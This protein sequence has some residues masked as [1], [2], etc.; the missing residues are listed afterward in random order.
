MEMKFINQ[1][2]LHQELS[3]QGLG[4]FPFIEWSTSEIIRENSFNNLNINTTEIFWLFSYI[5]SNIRSTFIQFYDYN[6]EN[7]ILGFP[8]VQ[9]ELRHSIETF[10][11]LN[12]LVADKNYKCVL[13]YCSNS[14]KSNRKDIKLGDYKRF[15]HTNK[16]F[17]IQSKYEISK[18]NNKK[19]LKMA[20]ASNSY[21]HPDVYLDI[22]NIVNNR[23]QLLINL[24]EMN[25]Y[26]LSAS[27]E[28]FIKGIEN[29][30]GASTF[31]LNNNIVAYGNTCK[32]MSLYKEKQLLV[33]TTIQNS[34]IINQPN[35]VFQ[36]YML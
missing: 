9:R 18:L 2:F 21:T 23:E 4:Y 8:T 31:L 32:Y 16:E 6:I 26:L 24:F 5:K 35:Q 30:Y 3:F 33:N 1:N 34:L 27:Y 15:L 19:L 14:N 12:N 22:N 28:L 13:S 17:T 29:H 11:D 36:N 25:I 10:L 20:S 7:D